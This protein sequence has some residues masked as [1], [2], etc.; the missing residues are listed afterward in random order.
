MFFGAPS[1]KNLMGSAWRP[2]FGAVVIVVLIFKA[3]KKIAINI[4]IVFRVTISF[5]F[6]IYFSIPSSL[7]NKTS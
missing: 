5:S 1:K 4:E 2:A 7:R 3:I 6:S